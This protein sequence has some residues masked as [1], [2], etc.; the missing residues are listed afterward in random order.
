MVVVHRLMKVAHF[1]V[2]KSMNSTS[3][4]AHIL[5]KDVVRLHGIPKRSYLTNMP[6]SIPSFGKNCLQVWGQH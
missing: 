1:F 2:V 4:I 3:Y 6:S 5:I